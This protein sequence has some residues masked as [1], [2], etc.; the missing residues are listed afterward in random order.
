VGL[1]PP[2]LRQLVRGLGESLATDAERGTTRSPA[3]SPGGCSPLP[4]PA[5]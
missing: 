5:S 4:G 1:L 2:S 3:S